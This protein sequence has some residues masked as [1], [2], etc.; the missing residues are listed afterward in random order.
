MNEL[1]KLALYFTY[2]AIAGGVGECISLGIV[3]PVCSWPSRVLFI[4]ATT[5]T[6]RSLETAPCW[7]SSASTS[8]TLCARK[9]PG[10]HVWERTCRP[11]TQF[12]AGTRRRRARRWTSGIGPSRHVHRPTQNL[13][14]SRNRA[15]AC[16]SGTIRAVAQS[17]LNYVQHHNQREEYYAGAL[18]LLSAYG[19]KPHP[20]LRIFL[21]GP[22]HTVFLSLRSVFLCAIKS[23]TRL[24][25]TPSVG[26]LRVFERVRLASLSVATSYS[27]ET[28]S[29]RLTSLSVVTSF[30][31][32]GSR[33]LYR[34]AKDLRR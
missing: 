16:I 12:A 7:A 6:P 18:W 19:L 34:Q 3:Q 32:F 2:T 29:D 25:P 27:F 33:R 23:R 30:S 28:G 8:R 26:T 31:S 20:V 9:W 14:D 13:R 24:L 22:E 5:D 15:L 21:Y 4:S 17:S 10:M 1:E 11:A